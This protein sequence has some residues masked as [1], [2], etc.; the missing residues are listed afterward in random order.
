[1]ENKIHQEINKIFDKLN[2]PKINFHVVK[3]T[4]IE[5]GEYTSNVALSASKTLS[6]RPQEIA[7][8]IIDNFDNKKF[9]IKEIKIMGPGFINFYFDNNY[10][11]SIVK[12]IFQNPEF[13]KQPK[14]NKVINNEYVSANPT[15]FLH[16]AHARG[17]VIGDSI[18]NILEYAG[19]KV[20]RE[21]YINDAGLSKVFFDP[22]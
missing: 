9:N 4:N 6:T 17:A 16:V 7:Q 19:Y 12:E 13:G 10:Y 18:S 22:H 8:K 20:I 3:P 2:W 21:Y 14:N 1:M 5:F 11:S 15:G